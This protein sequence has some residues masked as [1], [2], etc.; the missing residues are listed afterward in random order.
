MPDD[1]PRLGP[2]DVPKPVWVERDGRWYPGR[3]SL[4]GEAHR[5]PGCGDEGW[6]GSVR[7]HVGPGLQHVEWVHE[8][9]VRQRGEGFEDPNARD[10]TPPTAPWLE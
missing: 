10:E 5:H 1:D 9:R 7:Y 8:G 6:A 2:W 3:L 4:W